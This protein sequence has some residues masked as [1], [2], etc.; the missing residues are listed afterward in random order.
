MEYIV[1]I[2]DRSFD[3]PKKTLS[4]VEKIDAVLK[5]D[6]TKGLSIRQRFEKLHA[7]VKEMVGEENAAEALGSSNLSEIDLSEIVLATKKIID[8]YEK[9]ITDYENEK[10]KEQYD[11][12]PMDK[13]IT[14]TKAAQSFANVQMMNK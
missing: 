4:V 5:V 3:L 13:I 10:K 14:M 1:I 11:S 2:N 6:T 12:L 9:P 8:A 7:F